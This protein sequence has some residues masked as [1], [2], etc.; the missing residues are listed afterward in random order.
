M[1]NS[2]W[3]THEDNSQN[4]EPPLAGP[5]CAWSLTSVPFTAG[6]QRQQ[7][8]GYYAIATAETAWV[9]ALVRQVHVLCARSNVAAPA[10]TTSL[11]R[12]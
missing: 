11:D 6:T 2:V 9:A 4:P 8:I 1:S 5:A 12:A 3:L 10:S 7:M